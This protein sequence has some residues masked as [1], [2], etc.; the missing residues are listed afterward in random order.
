MRKLLALAPLLLAGCGS[1]PLTVEQ[2]EAADA[3]ALEA[4]ELTREI[5]EMEV[6]D[7][8]RREEYQGR[9]WR[10]RA[11]WRAVLLVLLASA[12]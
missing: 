12:R 6:E 4:F 2:V 8:E 10:A 3:V 5:I 7:P 1:G 11:S 9:L